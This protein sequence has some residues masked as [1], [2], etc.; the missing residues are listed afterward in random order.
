MHRRRGGEDARRASE[1]LLVDRAVGQTRRT[2]GD[3]PGMALEGV[4]H[5]L[6]R[7]AL[8]GPEHVIVDVRTVPAARRQL[9]S[10]LRIRLRPIRRRRPVRR[11]RP[12]RAPRGS[13]SRFVQV[14]HPGAV[15][16]NDD[17]RFGDV[18][19]PHRRLRAD[20]CVFVAGEQRAK[21]GICKRRVP[22]S[23]WMFR[24][25][26]AASSGLAA[27]RRAVFSFSSS[28][29]PVGDG[30]SKLQRFV[31]SI[32]TKQAAKQIILRL[33][34]VVRIARLFQGGEIHS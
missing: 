33:G 18:R 15:Q 17:C 7:H 26:S 28:P 20:L 10:P 5:G 30:G 11:R 1:S 2:N 24:R 32:E 9:S 21:V 31:G 14:R 12:L 29:G 8:P 6:G 4:S 3:P 25:R 13:A 19:E 27:A 16:E 34:K 22:T 23:S